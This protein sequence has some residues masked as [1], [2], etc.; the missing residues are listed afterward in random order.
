MTLEDQCLTLA[1]TAAALLMW[2]LGNSPQEVLFL[3]VLLSVID[4]NTK[5]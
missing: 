5:H 3:G 2:V 4:G 1:K